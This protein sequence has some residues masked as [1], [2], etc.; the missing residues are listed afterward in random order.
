MQRSCGLSSWFKTIIKYDYTIFMNDNIAVLWHCD[1]CTCITCFSTFQPIWLSNVPVMTMGHSI[2]SHLAGNNYHLSSPSSV[3]ESYPH[4]IPTPQGWFQSSTGHFCLPML[5]CLR[6]PGTFLH[7]GMW[8]G[9]ATKRQILDD[10]KRAL[11]TG[12]LGWDTGIIHDYMTVWLVVWNIFYREII[13]K[14]PGNNGKSVGNIWY[15][16]WWWL[17]HDFYFSIYWEFHHPNGLSY[18]SEG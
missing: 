14:W 10:E 8:W 17:E 18:F 1:Q 7:P 9:S 13:P 6:L 12:P 16:G 11:A 4:L 15:T 3:S 2:Y 5:R